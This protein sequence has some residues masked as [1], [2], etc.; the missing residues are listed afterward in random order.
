MKTRKIPL[1]LPFLFK[2]VLLNM[3]CLEPCG[4]VVGLSAMLPTRRSQV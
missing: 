2:F 3:N 4:I 1:K